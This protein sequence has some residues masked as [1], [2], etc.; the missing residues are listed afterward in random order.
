MIKQI[1]LIKGR[2]VL[3]PQVKGYVYDGPI[4]SEHLVDD[5]WLYET[6]E[7]ALQRHAVEGEVMIYVTGLTQALIATLNACRAH[8]IKVYLVHYDREKKSW[9]TQGVL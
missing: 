2:H 7:N 6:A 4:P 5:R 1:G 9:W 8:G 3:P